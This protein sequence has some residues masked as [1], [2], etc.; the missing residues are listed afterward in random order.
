[1]YICLFDFFL[2][3]PHHFLLFIC[4][5]IVEYCHDSEP[6][7]I[8]KSYS[9]L[10]RGRLPSTIE[11][12]LVEDSMHFHGS[13]HEALFI[14]AWFLQQDM[15]RSRLGSPAG[16]GILVAGC[17]DSHRVSSMR[18]DVRSSL[19]YGLVLWTGQSTLIW[20]AWLDKDMCKWVPFGEPAVSAPLSTSAGDK[21]GFLLG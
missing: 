21:E 18:A 5:F 17:R 15:T 10:P 9:Y 8:I 13:F 11:W 4:L 20:N 6:K 1:M 2:H 19:L 16:N 12:K 3:H 7:K 14:G